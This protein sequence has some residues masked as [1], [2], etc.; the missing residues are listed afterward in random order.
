MTRTLVGA[1]EPDNPYEARLREA[2]QIATTGKIPEQPERLT[3]RKRHLVVTADRWENLAAVWFIRRGHSGEPEDEIVRLQLDG[4]DWK[5]D[6]ASGGAPGADLTTRL[7]FDELERHFS[8]Q[9]HHTKA[10]QIPFGFRTG[11]SAGPGRASVRFQTVREATTLTF[12]DREPRSIADHGHCLVLYNPKRPPTITALDAQ[13]NNLG[14][15]TPKRNPHRQH[16]WLRHLGYRLRRPRH[17]AMLNRR[18][19]WRH[20]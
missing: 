2:I 9:Y 18:R 13:E 12:S 3:R 5:R 15:F 17:R 16:L 10:E 20:H 14:S 19:R 1:D 7:S 11:S 8:R 6:G 4:D